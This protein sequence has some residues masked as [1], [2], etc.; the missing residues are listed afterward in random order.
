LA[1]SFEETFAKG[2][3][4]RT[5]ATARRCILGFMLLQFPRVPGCLGRATGCVANLTSPVFRFSGFPATWQQPL[6]LV[7]PLRERG[8]WARGPPDVVAMS[9]R[10]QGSNPGL[11][12]SRLRSVSEGKDESCR[13]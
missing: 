11:E 8:R 5:P 4:Q 10:R 9:K 7:I 13:L 6:Q 2:D 1:A 12:G 3:H